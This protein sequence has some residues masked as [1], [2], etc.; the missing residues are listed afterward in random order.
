MIFAPAVNAQFLYM[1]ECMTKGQELDMETVKYL[2]MKQNPALDI[3][4]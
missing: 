2:G 3:L 1:I 4:D